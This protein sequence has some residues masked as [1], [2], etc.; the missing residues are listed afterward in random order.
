MQGTWRITAAY[1]NGQQASGDATLTIAGD[2]YTMSA[3][4]V[5]E[6][7]TFTLGTGGPHTI[8]VFH[9]D[10]PLASQGFYGG[11][12]TGIYELSGNRLRICFDGTGRTYPTSFDASAGSHRLIFEFTRE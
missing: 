1:E 4:G 12:L 5:D 6:Q 11:T 9:H 2:K 8:R 3:N 7:S 10:N